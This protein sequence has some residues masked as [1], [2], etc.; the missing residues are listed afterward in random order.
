M[1]DRITVSNGLGRSPD[2]RLM[3]YADS[4]THSITAFDFDPSTADMR[5][6]RIF[7]TDSGPAQPDGLTVDADGCV[8]SAKWDGSKV[9]RYTAGVGLTAQSRCR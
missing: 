4:V 3:Y 1:L 9:I 2:N 6:P 8:W 5:N 7:A